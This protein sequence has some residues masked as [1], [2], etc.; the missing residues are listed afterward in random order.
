MDYYDAILTMYFSKLIMQINVFGDSSFSRDN[1]N[2]FDTIL[3][4]QK[5][6]L[7]NK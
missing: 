5:P 4:V 2:N 7:R 6:F 1:G 3:F